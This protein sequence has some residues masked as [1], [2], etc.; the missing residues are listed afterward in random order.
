MFLT[1]KYSGFTLAE[2]LITLAIIG[3]VAAFTIPALMQSIGSMQY[4]SAFK[5]QF[6]VFSSVI[7]ELNTEQ[8]FPVADYNA[9]AAAISNSKLAYLKYCDTDSVSQGCWNTTHKTIKGETT[10]LGNGCYSPGFILKDGAYFCIIGNSGSNSYCLSNK[11]IS[12]GCAAALIDVNGQKGPNKFGVDTFY[13]W[14]SSSRLIPGGDS[15]LSLWTPTS[16]YCNPDLAIFNN[17]NG[18]GCAYNV[19]NNIDY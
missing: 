14:L 18:W 3:V 11:T 7:L 4:K 13:V 5:K 16:F 2:V 9:L 15:G 8:I 6:S 1:G 12:L 17:K 19:L 10:P